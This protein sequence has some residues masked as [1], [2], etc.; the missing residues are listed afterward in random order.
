MSET[1]LYNNKVGGY[2]YSDMNT[3]I[4]KNERILKQQLFEDSVDRMRG[5]A[6]DVKNVLNDYK[7]NFHIK[8]RDNLAALRA[9]AEHARTDDSTIEPENDNNSDAQDKID[10]QNV[11]R[12]AEIRVK[13]GTTERITKIIRRDITN[14]ILRMTDNSNFMSV[15]Q[16]QIHQLFTNITEEA[17]LLESSNI[18]RQFVNITGTIFY[19]RE[20]VV[21][22]A[23]LMVAMASKFLGYG[24]RIHSKLRAVVI[25]ANTEWPAQ[26]TWGEEISFSHRNI[27][28][29]YKYNHVHGVESIIKIL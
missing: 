5:L 19:W 14:P 25:L 13:K 16:Y 20:K 4:K 12:L 6:S 11:L 27:V 29:R 28:A 24:V 10:D 21:T 22:N 8:K 1:R 18:R 23:K 9:V 3:L 7:S 26:Q 17:E 2:T 15:D